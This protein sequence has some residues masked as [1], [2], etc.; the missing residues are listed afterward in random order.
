LARARLES[1]LPATVPQRDTFWPAAVTLREGIFH[2]RP[3]RFLSSGDLL[4][5]A[6]I[7]GMISLPAG[8]PVPP[9]GEE[10]SF[11]PLSLRFP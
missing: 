4:G 10:I 1:P 2:A 8:A 3:S 7:N 5:I 6:R 11:L 9:P